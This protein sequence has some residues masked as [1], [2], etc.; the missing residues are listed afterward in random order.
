MKRKYPENK[1]KVKTTI[2]IDKNIDE[3]FEEY[4][5]DNGHYNKSILVEELIKMEIDRDKS[6]K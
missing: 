3:V 2:T 1:K 5:D 6:K 4:I